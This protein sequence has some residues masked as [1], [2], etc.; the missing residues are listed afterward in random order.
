D[1]THS[2]SPPQSQHNGDTLERAA[3]SRLRLL[4]LAMRRHL[5]RGRNTLAPPRLPLSAHEGGALFGRR[6]TPAGSYPAKAA[7][8]PAAVAHQH[9]GS[10]RSIHLGCTQEGAVGWLPD[11]APD[12]PIGQ[13]RD[14]FDAVPGAVPRAFPASSKDAS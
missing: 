9:D 11:S 2:P 10:S 13:S 4:R 5:L 12:G 6:T 7:P 8:S 3:W 14:G 1:V